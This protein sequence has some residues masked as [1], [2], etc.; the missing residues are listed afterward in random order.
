MDIFWNNHIYLL[1]IGCLTG[2]A[3]FIFSFKAGIKSLEKWKDEMSKEISLIKERQISL[4]ETLPEKY[5]LNE[6]YEI[7]IR[8]IKKILDK[9]AE[10][11]DCKIDKTAWNGIN[12]R[13]N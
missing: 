11:L 4:R 8:E 2:F 9:I 12:R 1:Y 10:K 7:H 6:R 3:Y 5:V 13:K